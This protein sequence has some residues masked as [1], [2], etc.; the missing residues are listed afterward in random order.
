MPCSYLYNV[1]PNMC[2][3]ACVCVMCV[4]T[5]GVNTIKKSFKGITK[6][7][8]AACHYVFHN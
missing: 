5:I 2:V 1:F 3:C 6:F 8:V 7:I 4:Y